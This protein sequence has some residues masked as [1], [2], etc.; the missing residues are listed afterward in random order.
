MPS[1]VFYEAFE[2]LDPFLHRVPV[3]ALSLR[4]HVHLG[5]ALSKSR[6]TEHFNSVA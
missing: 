6:E 2:L 5:I 4:P 1:V 3:V